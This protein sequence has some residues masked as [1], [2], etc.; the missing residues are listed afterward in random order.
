[1]FPDKGGEL[2]IHRSCA[3]VGG[4]DDFLIASAWERIK[5]AVAKTAAHEIPG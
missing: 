4:Q 3:V 1:M 2:A 5:L